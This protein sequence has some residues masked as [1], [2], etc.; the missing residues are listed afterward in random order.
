MLITVVLNISVKEY[1]ETWAVK[2]KKKINYKIQHQ[3]N[4]T[5]SFQ[6][7]ACGASVS[8]IFCNSTVSS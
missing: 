5:Q 7:S 8:P 2:K 6:Y 1:W 3:L 4:H